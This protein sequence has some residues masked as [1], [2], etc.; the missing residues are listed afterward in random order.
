MSVSWYCKRVGWY[1]RERSW[2][3]EPIRLFTP[4]GFLVVDSIRV[5]VFVGGEY[6]FWW[7]VEPTALLLSD[8]HSAG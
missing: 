2:C 7:L 4:T 6:D 1:R 3:R 8:G 5:R